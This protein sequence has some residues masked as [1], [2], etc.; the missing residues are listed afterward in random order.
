MSKIYIA[1]KITGEDYQLVYKKFA[2]TAEILTN[3]GYDVINPISI[4]KPGT[5]WDEAM[6]I[7]KPYF[8]YCDYILLLPDWNKSKGAN[9]EVEWANEFNIP[10]IFWSKLNDFLNKKFIPQKIN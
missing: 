4:I 10:I 7:L 3:A 1:G 5:N 6:E 2:V 9:L 8:I